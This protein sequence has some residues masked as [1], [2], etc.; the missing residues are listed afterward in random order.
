VS[1]S[2]GFWPGYAC[3]PRNQQPGAEISVHGFGLALD[4]LGFELMSGEQLRIEPGDHAARER[5]FLD[6]LRASACDYFTT[7]LGPGS[8]Q[9]HED[10]LHVD[11][12]P[13]PND[14]RLCR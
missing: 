1:R 4:I 11:L 10:H 6:A 12:E 5:A 9:H 2:P 13:R 14:R 3:R 8:D 7:V